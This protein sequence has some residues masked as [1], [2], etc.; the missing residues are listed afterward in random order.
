LLLLLNVEYDAASGVT[1]WFFG[2]AFFLTVQKFNVR[3]QEKKFI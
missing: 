3:Y 2:A 1:E